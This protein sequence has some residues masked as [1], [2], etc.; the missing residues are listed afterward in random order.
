MRSFGRPRVLI[1]DDEAIVRST[2]ERALSRAG[3]NPVPA[4]SGAEAVAA[5]E[6][7]TFDAMVLDV[8]MPDVDG[9][10]ALVAI[11]EHDR[12]IP[13]VVMSGYSA[14]EDA[15]QCLRAGAVDFI[16]KPFEPE[17][18]L[19]A[20]DRAVATNYQRVD[21]A[22]LS[23]TKQIFS[24]LDVLD[25][26]HRFLSLSCK[27]LDVSETSLTLCDP[28]LGPGTFRA[29][30]DVPN[31]H[32]ADGAPIPSSTWRRVAES[33]TPLLLSKGEESDVPVLSAVASD[34]KEAIV[35]RLAVEGRNLA[36]LCGSR[37]AG[38]R[39][40]GERDL[41]RF[42]VVSEHVAQALENARRHA[43]VASRARG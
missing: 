25:V 9:P 1:V 12:D 31:D 17:M 14:F 34:A 40:F 15:V 7:D 43:E 41:R 2:C 23:A 4:G 3:Y 13:C 36:F 38:A 8:R 37:S 26:T 10:M 24:S 6:R 42:A 11:R 20:V 39:A 16:E 32:V 19:D 27:L 29:R 5:V 28:A 21:S 22:L 18:L 30:A 35:H 33:A